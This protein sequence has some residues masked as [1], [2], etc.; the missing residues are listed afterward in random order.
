M[1]ES[2]EPMTLPDTTPGVLPAEL[3]R[4]PDV[5][6]CHGWL[7]L[8]RRGAWRLKGEIVRHAGLAAF[9]DRN[10]TSEP[11]GSWLVRNGP[12]RVYVTLEYAP[13]VFRIG[14]GGALATHTGGDAGAAR[15]VWLDEAGNVLVA[16]GVGPGLL[17]DRDVAAF[18]GECV[19]ADGRPAEE[20]ALL[21]VMDGGAGVFWRGLPLGAL[22]GDEVPARFGFRRV[23]AP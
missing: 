9:L 11:D 15:G 1:H 22:R 8:D 17:D 7:S 21:A 3:P 23:P 6:A 5:P 10:Y 13:W 18:V 16:A 2:V 14:S 20:S 12:Q 4:W 19:G